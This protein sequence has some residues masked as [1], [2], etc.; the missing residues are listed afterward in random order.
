MSHFLKICDA[1][2]DLVPFVQFKIVQIVPNG[3]THHIFEGAY[4][5]Y[6]TAKRIKEKVIE[7]V[8]STCYCITSKAKFMAACQFANKYPSHNPQ[9]DIKANIFQDI[10]MFMLKIFSIYLDKFFIFTL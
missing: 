6:C 3:G 9:L 5:V 7:I 4:K 2:R 1:L 10:C 8:H